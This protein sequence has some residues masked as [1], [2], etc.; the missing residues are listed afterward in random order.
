[1]IKKK[2]LLILYLFII[3][4]STCSI[5][6]NPYIYFTEGFHILK[7]FGESELDKRQYK[8]RN[9]PRIPGFVTS[10]P[11]HKTLVT[12]LE[13][14][15]Y[16]IE[17]EYW[18][19]TSVAEAELYMVERVDRSPLY[20]FNAIDYPLE[21]VEI[22]D[23]CYYQIGPN[24]IFFI[25]NNVWVVV[26]PP[27]LLYPSDWN[28]IEYVAKQIDSTIIYAD[29]VPS[30]KQ[31]PAP[32]VHSIEITSDLPQNWGDY[33]KVKVTATDPN[34]LAITYRF[35]GD[36]LSCEIENGHDNWHVYRLV[37]ACTD[38]DK[39]R[40]RLWAW[41]ENNLIEYA[42]KEFSFGK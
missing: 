6:K 15:T 33:I 36:G 35:L 18:I 31:V 12:L 40:V 10:F 17:V 21:D 26:G 23:N 25:R 8:F 30:S 27:S 9:T 3:L 20:F 1:M 5:N 29:K 16:E 32:K 34:S 41:N 37:S 19:F 39:F 13:Q 11:A 38:P 4:Y 42:E 14:A 24:V 7:G 28:E 22:G 2:N